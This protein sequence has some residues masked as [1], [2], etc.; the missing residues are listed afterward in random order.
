MPEA[1]LVDL[2]E[3]PESVWQYRSTSTFDRPDV[4]DLLAAVDDARGA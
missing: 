3:T 4:D 1:V 2:G